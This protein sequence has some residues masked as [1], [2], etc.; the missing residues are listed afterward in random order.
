M[1]ITKQKRIHGYRRQTSGY[2]WREGNAE[3]NVKDYE[4]QTT[5]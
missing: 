1:C 4:I 5:V 3:G 2:Q